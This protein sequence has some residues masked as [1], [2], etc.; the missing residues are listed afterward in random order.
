MSAFAPLI[1]ASRPLSA[2]LSGGL[3]FWRHNRRAGTTFVNLVVNP[4]LLRRRLPG[5]K[6]PRPGPPQHVGRRSGVHRFTPVHPEP[7]V[8]G[9][10][11]VVPLG[12]ESEWARNVVAAGRCRIHFTQRSSDS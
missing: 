11:V 7:T 4:M 8:D 3:V 9:F 5:G 12:S 6:T 1:G 10:R 2:A